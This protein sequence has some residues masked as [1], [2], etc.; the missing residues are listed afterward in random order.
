MKTYNITVPFPPSVNHYWYHAKQKHFIT[1]KG[2][3]YRQLI[4][5]EI[6]RQKLCKRLSQRLGVE[7]GVYPPD[8][9]KRDLDNLMKAPIDALCHGGLIVDDSQIDVLH[10]ERKEIIKGGKLVIT[11][12]EIT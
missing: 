12:W 5:A 11:I 3:L 4:V 10:V 8:R 2:K 1:P 6:M 7:I 9:R